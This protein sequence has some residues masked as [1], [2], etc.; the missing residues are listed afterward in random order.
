MTLKIDISSD[1]EARLR[2]EA[3]KQGVDVNQYVVDVLR[4]RVQSRANG[5]ACLS[6]EESRWLEEINAGLSQTDWTRY[7]DLVDKRQREELTDN[8]HAELVAMADRIEELNVRRI[9]CLAELARSRGKSLPEMMDQL[10]IMPP[11]VR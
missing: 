5:E 10:Q 9:E 7:Y 6:D 8:E 2:E 11:A 1:L 4:D 3:D